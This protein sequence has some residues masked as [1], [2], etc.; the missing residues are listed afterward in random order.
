MG[1]AAAAVAAAA[2]EREEGVAHRSYNSVVARSLS[3]LT[4]SHT[5]AA[6]IVFPNRSCCTAHTLSLTHCC[7]AAHSAPTPLL[8]LSRSPFPHTPDPLSDSHCGSI[9]YT[10]FASELRSTNSFFSFSLCL[11]HTLCNSRPHSGRDLARNSMQTRPPYW[12]LNPFPSHTHTRCRSRTDSPL[13]LS[14]YAVAA[15]ADVAIHAVAAHRV[16]SSSSG[17][18]TQL[19]CEPVCDLR[20]RVP[21]LMRSAAQRSAQRNARRGKGLQSRAARRSTRAGGGGGSGCC[22]DDASRR[23]GSGTGTCDTSDASRRALSLSLSLSRIR[24][25]SLGF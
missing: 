12:L 8:S 24:S 10:I 2:R 4:H 6:D 18:L 15:T 23:R 11:R 25:G 22:C 20:A 1:R 19:R 7:A 9:S 14:C 13:S 16:A 21:V 5:H 17:S 3:L